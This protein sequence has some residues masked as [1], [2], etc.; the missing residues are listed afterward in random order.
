MSHSFSGEGIWDQFSFILRL[1]SSSPSQDYKEISARASASFT[2]STCNVF[3]P[4]LMFEGLGMIV[5]LC[6]YWAGE[7]SAQHGLEEWKLE[8]LASNQ[9]NK[10]R[11]LTRC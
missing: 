9:G 10:E 6:V 2:D 4:R 7:V 11:K 5:S 3:S 8:F 1:L